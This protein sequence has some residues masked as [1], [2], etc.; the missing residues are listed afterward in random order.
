LTKENS[1]KSHPRAIIFDW[2]N[3][4]VSSMQV[5]CNALNHALKVF[6]KSPIS[7][8]QAYQNTHQSPQDSFV[9]LF[10][11]DASKAMDVFYEFMEALPMEE[12]FSPW[13][14]AEAL[15]EKIKQVGIPMGVVSNKKPAILRAEISSV[16][17]RSYFHTVVGAGEA[18]ADKPSPAPLNLA[19]ERMGLA[20]APTIWF[21][22]D[23]P[24]DWA[25]AQQ[26]GCKPLSIHVTPSDRSV[27]H[28]TNFPHLEEIIDLKHNLSLPA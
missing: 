12:R 10:G 26:S 9:E 5:I 21:I 1:E 17:W 19:L 4:L 16:G 2:D 15:L 27:F 13:P 18:I 28:V 23:S 11:T 24:V 6:N 14:G 3:T 7:F 22:G 8:D 20:P 25:C